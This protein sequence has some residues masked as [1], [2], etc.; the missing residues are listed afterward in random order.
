M[1]IDI[2]LSP[3]IKMGGLQSR[4]GRFQELKCH[5]LQRSGVSVINELLE[6]AVGGAVY[7]VSE[8]GISIE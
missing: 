3:N 4:S 7:L 5:V 8:S 6:D 1:P 2:P